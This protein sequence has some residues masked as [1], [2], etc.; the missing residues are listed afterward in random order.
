MSPRN[1]LESDDAWQRQV[2]DRLLKPIL[3]AHAFE[4]QMYFFGC[5]SPVSKLLQ[6]C[7]HVDAMTLSNGGD[8]SLELKIVRWPGVK[9]G[10][11][12]WC[13]Y[14]AFFLE[15]WSSSVPG[16]ERQGWMTTCIADWLLY[17]FCSAREDRL[18]CYPF[19]MGKLRAW[20]FKHEKTLKESKVPNPINGRLLWTIGRLAPK[21]IVCRELRIEGFRVAQQGLVCDL[22]G[23]PHLDFMKM[24][25]A[26]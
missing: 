18:D 12:A 1:E 19:P 11:P 9:H 6:Q 14:S 2:A 7:A 3:R 13:G 8:L 16:Y 26:A 5:S 23:K 20:F 24:L 15:T 17:C 10:K 4:G 21:T 22:F 25:P